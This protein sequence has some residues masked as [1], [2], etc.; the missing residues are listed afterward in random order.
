MEWESIVV[1]R[2]VNL[3]DWYANLF[4]K[5]PSNSTRTVRYQILHLL[6]QNFLN[7]HPVVFYSTLQIYS[8]LKYCT[9]GTNTLKMRNNFMNDNM[10]LVWMKDTNQLS[11]GYLTTCNCKIIG[12]NLYSS[13]QT[14]ARN[15]N[16]SPYLFGSIFKH[17]HRINSNSLSHAAMLVE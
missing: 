15:F 17:V 5:R 12:M 4:Q 8:I 6:N 11:A 3:G 2:R 14:L 9:P 7:L 13:H 16:R 1:V 10:F